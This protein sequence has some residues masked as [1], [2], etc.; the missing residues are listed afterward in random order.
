MNVLPSP[1][2]QFLTHAP[3]VGNA[4]LL[5]PLARSK[6]WRRHYSADS[7]VCQNRVTEADHLAVDPEAKFKRYGAHFGGKYSLD[8][9]E[10]MGTVPRIRMR[11]SS[12]RQK[13]LWRSLRW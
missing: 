4:Q 8:F 2:N 11:Q 1:S 10:L 12:D 7:H 9:N 3:A 5:R 13:S 6:R